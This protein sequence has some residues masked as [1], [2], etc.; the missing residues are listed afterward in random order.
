LLEKEHR[1]R[2]EKAGNETSNEVVRNV[3]HILQM[4]NQKVK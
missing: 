4:L 2:V 1:K 3:I